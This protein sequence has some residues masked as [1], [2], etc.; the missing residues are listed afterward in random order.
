M[1]TTLDGLALDD[2][3]IS[4]VMPVLAETGTVCTIVEWLRANLGPR[5]FEVIIVISPKSPQ[6]LEGRLPGAC[7]HRFVDSHPGAAGKPRSRPGVPGGVCAAS[8]ATSS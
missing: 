7:S 5:L 4:V 8:G 6:A 3:R 1:N 2:F